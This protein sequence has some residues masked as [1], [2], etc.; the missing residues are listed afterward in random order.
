MFNF[1]KTFRAVQR[2]KSVRR[3]DWQGRCRSFPNVEMFR[4]ETEKVNKCSAGAEML[5]LYDDKIGY[6]QDW[7]RRWALVD[8]HERR[9]GVL[10]PCEVCTRIHET[11]TGANTAAG[12]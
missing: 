1:M 10:C 8:A 5:S 9:R 3:L 2:N 6:C 12:L 7:F 11:P 4:E